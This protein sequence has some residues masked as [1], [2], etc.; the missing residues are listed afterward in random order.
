[1]DTAALNSAIVCVF[2]VRPF[3]LWHLVGRAVFRYI[4][5]VGTEDGDRK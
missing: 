1:M 3:T 5:V 4:M 2:S